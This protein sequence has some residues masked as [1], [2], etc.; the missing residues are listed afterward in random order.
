MACR[1]VERSHPQRR[2]VPTHPPGSMDFGTRLVD[3]RVDGTV[4]D[5][6]FGVCLWWLGYVPCCDAVLSTS[7]T[8]LTSDA[9]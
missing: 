1:E 7:V 8:M 2:P 4:L 9:D 6:S 3:A 5:C